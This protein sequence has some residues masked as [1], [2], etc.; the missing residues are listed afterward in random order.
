MLHKRV[1]SAEQMNEGEE[2]YLGHWLFAYQPGLIFL[3]LPLILATLLS[4]YIGPAFAPLACLR[5]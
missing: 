2:T 1:A 5:R 4:T 3:I